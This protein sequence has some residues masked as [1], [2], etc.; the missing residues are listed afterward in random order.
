MALGLLV[1]RVLTGGL[2]AAHGLR[3]L[4]YR[5]GSPG[6]AGTAEE[7]RADGLRGG[8]LAARAAGWTQATAGTLLVAGL[9]TSV[10]ASGVVGVMTVA[11]ATRRPHGFWSQQGGVE[12]PALLAGLGAVLAC[13]GPGAYSLDAAIGLRTVPPLRVTLAVLAGL[14]AA[15]GSLPALLRTQS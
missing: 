9:A 14:L 15:A 8:L 12:Y 7:F 2:V 5:F 13:T 3:K 10:A 1:L 11:A 4:T 6:P